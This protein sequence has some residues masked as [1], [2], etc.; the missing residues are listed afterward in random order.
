MAG[1]TTTITMTMMTKTGNRTIHWYLLHLS[2]HLST[3]EYLHRRV[4]PGCRRIGEFISSQ[5]YVDVTD[6]SRFRRSGIRTLE[7]KDGARFHEHQ[8]AAYHWTTEHFKNSSSG[9]LGA[10]LCWFGLTKAL[11][12][13][14]EYEPYRCR[15]SVGG[16]CGMPLLPDATKVCS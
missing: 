4:F 10:F 11:A 12:V 3:Q 5:H 16:T 8:L 13:S 9:L 15:R 2:L 1:R 14:Y 7:W 6:K